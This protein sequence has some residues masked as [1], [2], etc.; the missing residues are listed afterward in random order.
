MGNR[1][2]GNRREAAAKRAVDQERVF[3]LRLAGASFRQIAKEVGCSHQRCFDL[4]RAELEERAERIRDL[5]DQYV[6]EQVSQLDK[7]ILAHW[8]Q[9]GNPQNAQIILRCLDA[10]RKLLGLDVQRVVHEGT[11]DVVHEDAEARRRRILEET[12]DEI[13]SM[14]PEQLAAEAAGL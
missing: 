4:Y 12:A 9:R 10:K 7:L 14:T 11:V 1:Q 13:A 6:S 8:S 3:E 2:S 5:S